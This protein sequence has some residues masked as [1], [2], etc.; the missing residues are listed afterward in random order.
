MFD[1][2]PNRYLSNVSPSLRGSGAPRLVGKQP[3]R[4]LTGCYRIACQ[5]LLLPSRSVLWEMLGLVGTVVDA[6]IGWLVQ[7]ILGSFFT[8]QME[9][10]TC[11][12]GL[13]ED[14]KKLKSEMTTVEMVL[15]ASEGRK[16]DNKPLAQSV[17]GL[18]ELLYDAEDVMDELDYYRL[19][20]QIEQGHEPRQ[21]RARK[22][23]AVLEGLESLES[24]Q[25]LNIEMNP[26]LSTAWDFKLLPIS[27]SHLDVANLT[28]RDESRMLSILPQIIELGI[29]RRKPQTPECTEVPQLV[30]MFGAF[31]TTSRGL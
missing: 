3:H 10:W 30:T 23:L 15:A 6:A 5:V 8:A 16:I 12:I 24:L 14:V 20:Q 11:E 27:L 4:W 7:S 25:R 22:T 29:R 18:R 28:D 26:E 17:N 13:V 21:R 2:M 9:A 19:Q 31:V 1:E